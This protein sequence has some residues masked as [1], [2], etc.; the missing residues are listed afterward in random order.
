MLD[1]P[2]PLRRPMDTTQKL[3]DDEYWFPYHYVSQWEPHF[4][5]CF[6]DS[7]GINYAST[8]EFLLARLSQLD[9]HSLV[10]VGCGDGRLAREIAMRFQSRDVLGID[11]SARAIGLAKAMNAGLGVAFR[12]LDVTAA[13]SEAPRDVA[14]LVEVL[15]HIP[16]ESRRE[17]LHGIHRLLRPGATL[18]VTV[19]H[20]NVPLEPKHYEHFTSEALAR[21]LSEYFDVEEMV[22]F[23]RD[24]LARRLLVRLM[25]NGWFV[26]NHRGLLDRIYAYYKRNLVECDDESSCRRLFVVAR[27][28]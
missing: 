3:Q 28:K 24:G 23:E 12:Q 27:A 22:P 25:G 5:Q 18:F 20:A 16:P 14:T 15:E 17:F 1:E 4:S 8:T 19:P 11:Y 13:H 2:V 7:W 10:D 26:L 21:E 6:N 9:F